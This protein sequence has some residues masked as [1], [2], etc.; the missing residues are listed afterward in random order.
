[1]KRIILFAMC[2]LF[3]AI[4]FGLTACNQ[5][6]GTGGNTTRGTI[7]LQAIDI[8]PQNNAF[9]GDTENPVCLDIYNG[10]TEL[11]DIRVRVENPYNY[12][13]LSLKM[14]GTTIESEKFGAESTNYD[15]YIENVSVGTDIDE[16]TVAITDIAYEVSGETR[17]LT[18][19][20]GN[21]VT[22]L[23]DPDF[24]L[25]L[26]LSAAN[27]AEESVTYTVNYMAALPLPSDT[28]M[29]AADKYGYE[30]LIFVGWYSES[31]GGE[32]IEDLKYTYYKDVTFYARYERAFNYVS[33]GEQITVTGLTDAGKATYFEI[34]VPAE[35]DGLPVTAVADRAFATTGSGKTFRLPD[36][37]VSI[38]DY[39]FYNC[40]NLCVIMNGVREIGYAAFMNTGK[41]SLGYMLTTSELPLTLEYIG[42][43]AFSGSGFDTVFQPPGASSLNT[44]SLSLFIPASVN[45]IGDNAFS[46]SLFQAVYI[47]AGTALNTGF[48]PKEGDDEG[49]DYTDFQIGEGVF[50]NSLSLR[51]VITGY[52]FSARGAVES[53]TSG[54][55]EV[56]SDYMFY[57]CRS[58]VSASGSSG[59]ILSPGLKLI[60]AKAFS[61]ENVS[62]STFGL[63]ELKTLSMPDSLEH[64]GESAFANSA[65]QQVTFGAGSSLKTLGDWCF[66][67]T[68]ISE[69]TFYS[70][71]NYGKAP[72]WANTSM[73]SIYILSTIVPTFAEPSIM[74]GGDTLGLSVRYYVRASLL[75]RF[76]AAEGW[77][78]VSA[79]ILA[80]EYVNKSE[81]YAFEPVNA[82]G[83]LET[84][85][86]SGFA[87]ITYMYSEESELTIPSVVTADG[88]S[89][90]KVTDVGE[91]L[92]R[93]SANM[94]LLDKIVKVRI[95]NTVIRIDEC[96]FYEVSKLGNLVWTYTDGNGAVKEYAYNDV[97]GLK[98]ESIGDYAFG[99]TSLTYFKSPSTLEYVGV[100]AF[101]YS[102]LQT[103]DLSLG[104][105]AEIGASA[106][107]SNAITY[108]TVGGVGY[109]GG[110]AFANQS[111][112]T[113]TVRFLV[114][115]PPDNLKAFDPFL[116]CTVSSVFVPDSVAVIEF[117]NSGFSTTLKGKYTVGS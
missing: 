81:G 63:P 27:Y 46:S 43:Y 101:M 40:T 17:R 67:E 99:H 112:G 30:D 29:N 5:N 85:G 87:K 100:E 89:F 117:N 96:A 28:D 42:D 86:Q 14:N 48:L 45:Y 65:L 107:S 108:V 47:P 44:Y 94:S 35:I 52:T 2:V 50:K 11:F 68:Q 91:Y 66:Q 22:V 61:G 111:G 103:V 57:N 19:L 54:G 59:L 37:V 64:I 110:Y 93:D 84:S 36:T 98:L 102:A 116:N 75:A 88:M 38:G 82:D 49:Y 3:A 92:T 71:T 60:G 109:V 18:N 56:V 79:P 8:L 1:M 53:A 113:M 25:T 115:T 106:F 9:N 13:I 10:A 105:N 72:F 62:G 24:E 114:S 97:G 20:K 78:D 39:A 104:S 90:Y 31:E 74:E 80:Y 70:L 16:Y 41:M 12:K 33:D 26:D 32:K 77:K 73:K 95:P 55:L 51:T 76:R 69:I 58:L 83:A 7:S 23:I 21:E 6:S 34:V 4:A 15:I